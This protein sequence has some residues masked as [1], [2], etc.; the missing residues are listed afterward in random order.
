[1]LKSNPEIV[2]V[3]NLNDNSNL[4]L[5]RYF[6]TF[7]GT[8]YR[9]VI[10]EDLH[11]ALVNFNDPVRTRVLNDRFKFLIQNSTSV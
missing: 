7:D 8:G 5:I 2:K 9:E 3:F 4:G 11:K 6:A 1:M 10:E